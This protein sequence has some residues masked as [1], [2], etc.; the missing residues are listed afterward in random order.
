MK[1]PQKQPKLEGLLAAATASAALRKLTGR[2]RPAE[3]DLDS[4]SQYWPN[5]WLEAREEQQARRHALYSLF[6]L[7]GPCRRHYPEDG[8]PPA[9]SAEAR[10]SPYHIHSTLNTHS[11]SNHD[12]QVGAGWVNG[13]RMCGTCGMLTAQGMLQGCGSGKG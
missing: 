6:A 4:A 7:C 13:G 5:Q 11:L 9:H 3:D 1:S 2:K 12:F 8:R 10:R